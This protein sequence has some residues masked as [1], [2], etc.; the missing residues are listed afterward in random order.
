MVANATTGAGGRGRR[1]YEFSI[2]SNNFTMNTLITTT[3]LMVVA[4]VIAPWRR[5]GRQKR[6]N[7]G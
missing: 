4:N 1:W 5:R 7:F 6:D 3:H 2:K